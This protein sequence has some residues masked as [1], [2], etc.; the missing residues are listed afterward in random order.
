[1]KRRKW[2]AFESS[3][4]IVGDEAALPGERI[5][6]PYRHL[7]DEERRTYKRDWCWAHRRH[8][9]GSLHSLKCKGETKRTGCVCRKVTL[10][11]GPAA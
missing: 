7:S 6:R 9:V 5:T 11:S 2:E 1:M 3:L 4:T 10:Y 8:P